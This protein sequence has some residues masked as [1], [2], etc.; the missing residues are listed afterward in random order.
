MPAPPGQPRQRQH[1]RVDNGRSGSRWALQ[2]GTHFQPLKSA[3][4]DAN[5]ARAKSRIIAACFSTICGST[6]QGSPPTQL[7]TSGK[8]RHPELITPCSIDTITITTPAPRPSHAARH[9]SRAQPAPRAHT[10]AHTSART[11]G[12]ADTFM[13]TARAITTGH[14]SAATATAVP[15][16]SPITAKAVNTP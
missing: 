1:E 10:P 9:V 4:S 12:A 16:R 6:V 5:P 3:P 15:S 14:S 13:T 2:S 8:T 11:T 7:L